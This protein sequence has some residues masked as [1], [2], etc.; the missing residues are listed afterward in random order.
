MEMIVGM[1]TQLLGQLRA[2]GF[3]RARGA[4]DIRDLNTNSENWAVVKAVL[5]AGNYPKLLRVDRGR[6]QLVTQKED[7]VRF[8]MSSVLTH[9]LKT[10]K[11]FKDLIG[12]IP[13]DWFVYEEMVRINRTS[14]ARSV[15]LVNA[16]TLALF[17]GPSRL[18]HEIV[19]SLHSTH[20]DDAAEDEE[21]S[22]SDVEDDQFQEMS[23]FKIDEWLTFR[24]TPEVAQL[25]YPLRQKW[26]SLFLR[27]IS[28]PGK[29]LTLSDEAVIRTIVEVLTVEEQ[30][31]G[32][33][34]PVGVGQ[35]P[36]PMASDYCPPVGN[37][38]SNSPQR[39]GYSS[40]LPTRGGYRSPRGQHSMQYDQS[41]KYRSGRR[42]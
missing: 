8:H 34:Q 38:S 26:H 2:S 1:R 3:V 11:D 32:L 21:E 29:P 27:R 12:S 20:M 41:A 5:C 36:R 13:S 9:S 4:G 37:I 33:Q 15:T 18:P 23:I 14:F 30:R 19:T 42:Y 6:K 35:R 28:S 25:L 40:R 16:F 10:P 22:S 17:A 39:G 24:T 31:L 7:K